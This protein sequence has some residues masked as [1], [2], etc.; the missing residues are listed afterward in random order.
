MQLRISLEKWEKK[1][2]KLE[3]S[4][5][6]GSNMLIESNQPRF[7]YCVEAVQQE[8]TAMDDYRFDICHVTDM[9]I[10]SGFL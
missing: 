9:L 6:Y 2:T 7:A 4:N 5:L 8:W 3:P 10:Q 1:E